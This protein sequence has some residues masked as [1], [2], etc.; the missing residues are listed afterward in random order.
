M[1]IGHNEREL[2][3]GL[4][5]ELVLNKSHSAFIQRATENDRALV[6]AYRAVSGDAPEVAHMTLSFD[7]S[8]HTARCRKVFDF[9][10]SVTWS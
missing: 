9:E 1:L 5:L 2:A 8:V 4:R 6:A 7:G 3:T 10:S